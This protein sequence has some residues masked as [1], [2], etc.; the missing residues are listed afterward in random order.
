MYVYLDISVEGNLKCV[1]GIEDLLT[2]SQQFDV[3][4]RLINPPHLDCKPF[5][6]GAFNQQ[7]TY[8]VAVTKIRSFWVCKSTLRSVWA[9]ARNHWRRGF[10]A[11][12]KMRANPS[13]AFNVK[14]IQRQHAR[15]ECQMISS[16]FKVFC[17]AQRTVCSNHR[18]T[19]KGSVWA[20]S[21]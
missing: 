13:N 18:A 1:V 19:Q 12:L 17:S 9:H 16:V 7:S 6:Y 4:Y 14:S 5:L 20:F 10:W 8:H 21:G 2:D 15:K 11:G 3:D